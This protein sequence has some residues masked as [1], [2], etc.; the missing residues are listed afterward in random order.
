MSHV[1]LDNAENLAAANKVYGEFFEDGAEPACATVFVDWIPGGSH[2]EITCIATADLASRKVVR[3]ASMKYE[4]APGAVIASP[5]VWAGDTLYLSSLPGF[6]PSGEGLPEGLEEQ[7][8]QL[9]RNQIET[10]DAAGLKLDDIVGGFVYL[11][12]MNDYDKMNAVY[13]QYFS[14]GPGV[15]T[16]LMPGS[17]TATPS[18]KVHASFIGA[19]TQ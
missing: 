7:V 18:I 1:F 13:R 2:V 4:P 8:H 11:L 12:D 15:R 16:T 9:A 3:P 5:A 14:R 17:G 6:K 19:R 10:L